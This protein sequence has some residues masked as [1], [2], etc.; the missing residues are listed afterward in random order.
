MDGILIGTGWITK[1]EEK[2]FRKIV[3]QIFKDC[4]EQNT[5]SPIGKEY[6]EVF[7]LPWDNSMIFQFVYQGKRYSYNIYPQR[8]D[9]SEIG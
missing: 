3:F 5:F 9:F 2:K 1:D 8:A 6:S 7:I 4:F